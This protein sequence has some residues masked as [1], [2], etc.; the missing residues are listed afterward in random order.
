MTTTDLPVNLTPD[1]SFD[2]GGTNDFHTF[3]FEP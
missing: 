2:M 1:V 3:D